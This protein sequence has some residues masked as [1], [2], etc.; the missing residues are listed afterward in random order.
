[1][2]VFTEEPYAGN[3]LAVVL[4]ADGLTTQR[5]QAIAAEMN[6]SETAFVSAPEVPGADYR[7]RIFTPGRELPFAGHP[8]IG[9][10]YV[11]LSEGRFRS[12]PPPV[13]LHQQVNIGVL[14][15]D[16]EVGSNGSWRIVMTQGKPRFGEVIEDQGRLSSVLSVP[17]SEI[18]ETGLPTQIASTGLQQLFVPVRSLAAV[19]EMKPHLNRLAELE[20]AFEFTGCLAF[21]LETRSEE[22][23]AH[24]RYFTPSAGI[25]A[26][27]SHIVNLQAQRAARTR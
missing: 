2:D 18:M 6:L 7:L 25:S 20:E 1:M 23:F 15:I 13:T 21:C 4:D 24:V 12:A 17:V 9:A 8:S 5:M 14:P 10:A 19:A 3:P 22:T 26:G 16:L 11:L 27:I